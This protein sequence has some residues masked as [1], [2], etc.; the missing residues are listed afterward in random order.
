[1][2][3]LHA[4]RQRN[5]ST[6]GGC[7]RAPACYADDGII[8][9]TALRAREIERAHVLREKYGEMSDITFCG[10]GSRC[11]N[12]HLEGDGVVLAVAAVL[13]AQRRSSIS[14]HENSFHEIVRIVCGGA[15]GSCLA[16]CMM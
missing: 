13:L 2:M 16:F 5:V 12:K 6:R 7:R 9:D 10:R 11:V 1:M 8:A 14:S 4:A 15:G 3:A